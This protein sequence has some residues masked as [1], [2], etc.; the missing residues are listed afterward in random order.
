MR[1]AI[2]KIC[3]LSTPE[4]VAACAAGGATHAGFIF[5]ERSPRNV[6]PQTAAALARQAQE[7]GMRTVAVTVD[8]DN[9]V[10][11]G[12]VAAM[13]PD[14]LQLHGRETLQRVADVK[15]RFGRETWKALAISTRDDLARLDA[16][17][18]IAD[19]LLLDAKPP[20]G[21]ELPGGNAVSFDWSLLALIPAGTPWI[22]S[23]G[24]HAGNVADALAYD[25][26]GLDLSSG[27]E[28][29]PGV[30]DEGLIAA[31]FETLD[32]LCARD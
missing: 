29:A 9:A 12:I 14:V 27:V 23:G 30:K 11:D 17:H 8:A 20:K 24:I 32:G 6:T 28:S 21:S 31:F 26:P 7:A 16:Y 22:L 3:G 25:P 13:Q 1:P 19:R 10:L 4:T 18:G 15:A 5:F 2:V